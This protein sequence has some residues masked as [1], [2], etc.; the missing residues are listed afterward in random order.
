MNKNL[1]KVLAVVLMFAMIVPFVVSCG[2]QQP[3]QV[4]RPG[5]TSNPTNANGDDK[6]VNA[7]AEERIYPDIPESD[8]EG[9]NFR[10]LSYDPNN[11]WAVR[12]MYA[13]EL[14]EDPINDSVFTRN[15]A[16]EELL[17]IEISEV[18]ASNAVDLARKSI[19]SGLDEY[20]L[21]VIPSGSQMTL[22]QNGYLYR[23]DEMEYLDPTKPWWDNNSY[24][25][26]SVAD[27]HFLIV[28]DMQIM[29][30]DATWVQFFN[31]KM[32]D[33]YGLENPFDLVKNNEWTIDKQIEMIKEVTDD[34]NG[35]GLYT[36]EDTFGMVS[37]TFAPMGFFYGFGEQ[38]ATKNSDDI[39]ELTMNTPK[40][41]QIVNYIDE[42]CSVNSKIAFCGQQPADV[43]EVFERGRGLFMS[44][45][46][47]LAE[48]LRE[49][50]TDFGLIP[51]PKYDKDQKDYY[52]V[53]HSTT[54]MIS[55]PLTITDSERNSI[56]MEA[57]CAESKYTL[58]KAYYDTS[59]TTKFLRYD[60]GS[61]EMLDIIFAN[62]VYD[63]GFINDWGGYYNG[64][65]NLFTAGSKDFASMYAKNESKALKSIDQ[66]VERYMDSGL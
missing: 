42:I 57:L 45:V 15:K 31:K 22:A 33:D 49:M 38:I 50:D 4:T 48:R 18:A 32:I 37:T 11:E 26:L 27:A 9:Y 58:R 41:S 56:I 66:I 16:V 13:E 54:C 21:I 3:Q 29:D 2:E 17:K 64:F 7:D 63:L 8:F 55:V 5:T 46:L 14:N 51:H 34:T 39:P 52:S 19:A 43:Q 24:E 1:V 6:Q 60:D 12:D 23:L 25:S 62:R 10:I 44:E 65:I 47:Q 59:L 30:K 20:D 28:G 35:D 53:V 36:K 61:S 40:M